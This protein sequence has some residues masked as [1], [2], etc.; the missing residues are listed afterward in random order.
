MIITGK[1]YQ[2]TPQTTD[3]QTSSTSVSSSPVDSTDA[4][5]TFF[6]DDTNSKGFSDSVQISA[7][8]LSVLNNYMSGNA[9]ASDATSSAA[10]ASSATL[11]GTDDPLM[12]Y[13]QQRAKEAYMSGTPSNDGTLSDLSD[14]LSAFSDRQISDVFQQIKDA[15]QQMSDEFIINASRHGV[16]SL[17]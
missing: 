3:A 4:L 13:I 9:G 2:S 8:A 15:N 16:Q 17:L 10:T 14:Y 5:K 1:F 11:A 7:K 12:A 6:Q